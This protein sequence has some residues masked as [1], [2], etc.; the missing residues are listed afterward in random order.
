[1]DTPENVWTQ[2]TISE[3]IMCRNGYSKIESYKNVYPL[4]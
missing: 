2:S 4:E 3:S 1:M